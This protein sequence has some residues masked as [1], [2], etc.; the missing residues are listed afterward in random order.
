M[1]DEERAA[2]MDEYTL[3]NKDHPEKGTKAGGQL[4]KPP[5]VLYMLNKQSGNALS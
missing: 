5:G 3:V 2:C 4:K 1:P